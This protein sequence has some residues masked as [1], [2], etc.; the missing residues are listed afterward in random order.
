MYKI[1]N[2]HNDSELARYRFILL[3]QTNNKKLKDIV[4]LF[5]EILK[6]SLKTNS[7]IIGRSK[8][9]FITV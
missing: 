2:K 9:N 1:R 7:S 8:E 3:K 4:K 6:G 5:L